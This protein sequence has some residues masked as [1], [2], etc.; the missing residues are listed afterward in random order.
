[1]AKAILAYDD[2]DRRHL[3]MVDLL[4]CDQLVRHVGFIIIS[5]TVIQFIMR[6][7]DLSPIRFTGMISITF[8]SLR[9]A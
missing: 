5:F 3:C 1:M 2:C 8:S 6:P 4:E 9:I 7:P